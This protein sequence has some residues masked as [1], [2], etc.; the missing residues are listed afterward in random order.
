MPPVKAL[1]SICSLRS[2]IPPHYLDRTH[3]RAIRKAVLR[4]SCRLAQKVFFETS[5]NAHYVFLKTSKRVFQ[6]R[7]SLLEKKSPPS[8]EG[9]KGAL[10]Q[11]QKVCA[12]SEGKKSA[13][14]RERIRILANVC[15]NFCAPTINHFCDWIEILG[16]LLG[17]DQ[18]PILD[19]IK[20]HFSLYRCKIAAERDKPAPFIVLAKTI[21][22]CIACSSFSIFNRSA[23]F[24]GYFAT[25]ATAL[26]LS[27]SVSLMVFT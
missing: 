3:G 10:I 9:T 2:A 22:A 16:F 4:S 26:V 5:V 8:D 17:V 24:V 20:F 25:S 1:V 23:D 27:L 18:I 14:R 7:F 13:P 12:R 6:M 15:A 19:I 11:T 21:R